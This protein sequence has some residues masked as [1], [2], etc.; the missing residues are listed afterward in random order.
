MGGAGRPAG[1]PFRVSPVGTMARASLMS[2]GRP[3]SAAAVRSGGERRA[4]ARAGIVQGR[5]DRCTRVRRR[6]APRHNALRHD[7]VDR[8]AS[9]RRDCVGRSGRRFLAVARRRVGSRATPKGA[10]IA[11]VLLSHGARR[12]LVYAI[13]PD[14][15]GVVT[16]RV[17]RDGTV[18]LAGVMASEADAALCRGA[19]D[20]GGARRHARRG[21]RES[22]RRRRGAVRRG[23]AR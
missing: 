5:L 13:V 8:R 6:L 4:P 16:V 1:R 9:Y 22:G 18:T 10:E 23:A 3:A 12:V 15:S 20:G 14:K 7:R 11:P 21:A 17:L 2:A 19:D